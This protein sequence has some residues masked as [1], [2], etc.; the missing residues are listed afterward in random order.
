MIA[1]F[2]IELNGNKINPSLKNLNIYW[3]NF[4]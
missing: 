4:S 1:L 3:D 2:H